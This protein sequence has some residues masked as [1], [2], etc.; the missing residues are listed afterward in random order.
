MSAGGSRPQ[1]AADSRS[2]EKKF[3]K[4]RLKRFTIYFSKIYRDFF[5]ILKNIYNFV[6]LT[7]L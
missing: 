1:C 2:S 7:R 3:P 6:T 4:S 5:E